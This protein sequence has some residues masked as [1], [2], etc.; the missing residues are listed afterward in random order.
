MT[1]RRPATTNT[2]R[3]AG[4]KRLRRPTQMLWPGQ[5]HPK[6]ELSVPRRHF[7]QALQHWLPE[8]LHDLY[9][10]V[11]PD[12]PGCPLPPGI[13]DP[14]RRRLGFTTSFAVGQE[15]HFGDSDG[16]VGSPYIGLPL[17]EWR[18]SPSLGSVDLLQSRSELERV[19]DAFRHVSPTGQG[20][21]VTRSWTGVCTG[22]SALGPSIWPPP[23][24][25]RT[26]TSDGLDLRLLS[27][28]DHGH[29]GDAKFAVRLRDHIRCFEAPVSRQRDRARTSATPIAGARRPRVSEGHVRFALFLIEYWAERWGMAST[30]RPSLP[31][32]TSH[33]RKRMSGRMAGPLDPRRC[34]RG[35]PGAR[36]GRHREGV[37]RYSDSR[38]GHLPAYLV[39]AVPP[40]GLKSRDPYGTAAVGGVAA[41]QPTAA[42]AFHCPRVGLDVDWAK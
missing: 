36:Q 24:V 15:Q 34:L 33:D 30:L 10:S 21:T 22:A 39:V 5:F 31:P 23:L 7:F 14:V 9:D 37:P 1:R 2:Q 38:F 16:F 18:G 42:L 20:I 26:T 41:T 28:D 13:L 19:T 12:F 40:E 3:D 4:A 32:R 29:L 11:L 8:M 25:E 27:L 6:G 35:G 17:G